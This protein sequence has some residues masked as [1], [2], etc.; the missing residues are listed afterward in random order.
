M[1]FKV[2]A[3]CRG[4]GKCVKDCG[5]GVLAMKDGGPVVR[6]GKD[7]LCMNCQHCLAV[8]P[9]GAVTVNGVGPDACTPLE[10]M[11]IPPPVEVANLLMSR[12]SIR[13]F[14]KADIPRG[15]IAEMLEALKYVPTGCNVRHLVFRVVEGAAKM[16]VLRQTMMETLAAHLEALPENLRKIVLGWRKHPEVDVFFRG[17]P[18]VL[19]VYGDPKAVTPQVDCDAACAYFDLLAQANGVGT[20][21]FG[22]L[23]HMVEAVPEIADVFGIPRG[24]PFHAMLFGEPAVDYARC[25]N[26]AAGARIEW[27]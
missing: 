3:L 23:T 21:W 12:R 17:A 20:T 14:V 10:Q 16:E 27:A 26:R 25:V 4:C 5:F 7:E 2:S 15:E 18:H 1:E 13:Q 8:C 19:I 9:E 22:F 24:A 6:D 11:P